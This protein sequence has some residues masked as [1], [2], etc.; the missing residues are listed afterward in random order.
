M[1][2]CCKA[3]CPGFRLE[4]EVAI[5]P[6]FDKD[7]PKPERCDAAV[8]IRRLQVRKQDEVFILWGN[9]CGRRDDLCDENLTGVLQES[10]HHGFDW[11]SAEDQRHTYSGKRN[12]YPTDVQSRGGGLSGAAGTHLVGMAHA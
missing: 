10:K 4:P 12:M 6:V 2:G 5:W 7:R 11:S 1:N 8:P 3:S 9:L